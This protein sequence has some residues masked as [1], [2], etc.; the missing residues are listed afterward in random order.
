MRPQLPQLQGQLRALG[1]LRSVRFTGPGLPAGDAFEAVF[2]NGALV[3]NI[4]VAP[5]GLV[6]GFSMRPAAPGG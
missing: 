6:E 1:E 5:G 3:L 4:I 2:A